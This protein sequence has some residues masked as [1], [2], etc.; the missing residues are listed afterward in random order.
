MY[1]RCS[2]SHVYVGRCCN[3]SCVGFVVVV[4]D[5][6]IVIGRRGGLLS[7]VS[8]SAFK[9]GCHLSLSRCGDITVGPQ[10][11]YSLLMYLVNLISA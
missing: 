9:F 7:H 4:V 11:Y 10:I 3:S 6:V 2:R 5:V 1:M 8:R